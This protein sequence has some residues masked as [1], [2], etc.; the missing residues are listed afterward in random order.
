MWFWPDESGEAIL[1]EPLGFQINVFEVPVPKT[2]IVVGGN[3][4]IGGG[5]VEI[6]IR[7]VPLALP[8]R[9][10]TGGTEVVA[11]SGHRGGIKPVEILF[12]RSLCRT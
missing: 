3:R 9:V 8:I 6:G 12:D 11:Q 2:K 5:L 1:L 4:V 7:N 10:L